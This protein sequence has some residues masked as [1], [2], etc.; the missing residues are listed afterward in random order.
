LV[1]ARTTSETETKRRLSKMR[2][3]T[4]DTAALST[5]V[6]D[7][8]A[9]SVSTTAPPAPSVVPPAGEPADRFLQ[10]VWRDGAFADRTLTLSSMLALDGADVDCQIIEVTGS[11][12]I[13]PSK[14]PPLRYRGGIPGA[15]PR[16]GRPLL[17]ELM[18]QPG[19]LLTVDD[20]LRNPKLASLQGPAV[21]ATRLKELRRAFGETAT[22]PWFFELETMPWRLRWCPSRSWRIVERLAVSSVNGHGGG[23][24][25]GR[26]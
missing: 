2:I 12:T 15:G 6:Q 26:A 13:Q 8:A 21:R 4:E 14:G 7:S 10:T 5:A 19:Q 9:P 1:L 23:D 11:I 20:L 3:I 25:S 22:E 16:V 17:E 24:G 18:W